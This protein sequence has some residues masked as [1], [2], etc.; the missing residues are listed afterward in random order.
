MVELIG[1]MIGKSKAKGVEDHHLGLARI[2]SAR[3]SGRAGDLGEKG[4]DPGDDDRMG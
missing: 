1:V 2:P 4:A 3:E